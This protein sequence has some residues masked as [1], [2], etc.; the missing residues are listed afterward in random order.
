MEKDSVITSSIILACG[1]ALILILGIILISS[2]EFFFTEIYFGDSDSLP[3]RV[4]LNEDYFFSFI[5]ENKEELDQEY[6]YKLYLYL[7]GKKSLLEEGILTLE[8]GSKVTKQ[9]SFKI[10]EE[11]EEGIILVNVNSE[12]IYFQ[13]E[14]E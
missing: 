6:D 13:F 14:G 2:Q 5:I 4:I 11:F 3:N 8:R 12:Q 1:I 9:V 10:E 7:D